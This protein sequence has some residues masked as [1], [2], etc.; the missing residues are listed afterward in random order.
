MNHFNQVTRLATVTALL[1]LVSACGTVR[2]Q[3][4]RTDQEI[5]RSIEQALS[6]P[7][8]SREQARALLMPEPEPMI[9]APPE[10]RFDVF[11]DDASARE[12]LMSLVTDSD[13]NMVVHPELSGRVSLE[14][15]NV[16][17][18]EVLDVLRQVY[19]YEYRQTSAGYIVEPARMQTRIYEVDYLSLIR[20]GVSRTRVAS[21]QSTNLPPSLLDSGGGSS[22]GRSGSG[23]GGEDDDDASSTRIQTDNE[24]NFWEE[25]AAAIESLVA[26]DAGARVISNAQA[27]VVSVHAMPEGHRAVQE[28]LAAVEG[29]VQRQVIL[30]ARVIEVELRDEFRSGINWEAMFSIGG[31]DFNIGQIAGQGLFEEGRSAIRGAGRDIAVGTLPEGFSTTAFGGPFSLAAGSSDFSSFIELLETQGNTRVLSSPRIATVNNQKAVIKVGSDEFFVTGIESQTAA[32]TATSTT[33]STVQLTP[34]FSGVALD[35]TPQI[36]QDGHII[37]HVHPSISEVREQVKQFTTGGQ[38]ETLPLAFST[39]RESD[40]IIRA[41]SGEVVVIGGLMRDTVSEERIGTPGISRLPLVG[42]LFGSR[43]NRSVKTELVILLQPVV[44]DDSRVWADQAQQR[45]DRIRKLGG[46]DAA[47]SVPR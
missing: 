37:L 36:S 10:E 23:A 39:V 13:W 32:G 17:V 44:V 4:E 14:L 2:E 41:R 15:R 47:G 38:Q 7:E 8:L 35:V 31:T 6:A 16:T 30:E 20:T 22:F 9:E 12:F 19:G 43:Q 46:R 45:L 28:F 3:A 26:T 25:L 18:P 24:T 27:G 42:H 33:A 40:S 21:G 1:L 5:D 29:S 11:V 34:F